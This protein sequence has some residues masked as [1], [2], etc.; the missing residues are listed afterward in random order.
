MSNLDTLNLYPTSSC[1]T[2]NCRNSYPINTDGN[3]SNISVRGCT[4]PEYFDCYEK[5]VIDE[6]IEPKDNVGYSDIN[7]GAYMNKLAEG[8][9]QAPVSMNPCNKSTGVFSYDPRQF[10]TKRA[11]WQILDRTPADGAVT[12]LSTYDSRFDGYTTGYREYKDIVDGDITYYTDKSIQDPFFHPVFAEE[13]KVST[14]LYQDPMGAI[15][16]EYNRKAIL[17]TCN[18]TT[19]VRENYPYCLSYIQDTQSYR[20]DL[21]AL[22]TRKHNQSNWQN[23]WRLDS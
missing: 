2:F 7:P 1:N 21:M 11:Q 3:K 9:Y 15:K 18:P 4:I 6:D 10:D 20:E 5:V 16:P 17:N 23:R 14:V 13:A 12:T 22:Q 8:F 19:E